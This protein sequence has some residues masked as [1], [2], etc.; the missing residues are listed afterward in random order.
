MTR[1]GSRTTTS[2]PGARAVHDAHERRRAGATRA[3]LLASALV[4]GALAGCSGGDSPEPGSTGGPATTPATA[5][6]PAA[7]PGTSSSPGPARAPAAQAPNW[8]SDPTSLTRTIQPTPRL[9]EVRAAHNE[10]NGLSFD[11]VVLEF[12]GGLPGYS[13]R[14][15]DEVVRP[16]EGSALALTGPSDFEIVL[17]PAAAHDDAGQSTLRAPV[18]G[19]GGLPTIQQIMLAGDFEGYIHLGI[20]LVGKAGY[21]VTELTGPDRLIFDFAA[22]P[23]GA[24]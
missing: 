23:T 19:G 16:G 21:R 22:R 20:G 17:Y 8:P 1:R 18:A 15:V 5:G 6:N 3:L 13:A 24:P 14:Y 11:R 10:E 7:T 4:V 2:T 12:T 9:V